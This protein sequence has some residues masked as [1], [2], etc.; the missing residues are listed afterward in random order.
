MARLVLTCVAQAEVRGEAARDLAAQAMAP[1]I[2]L[3]TDG[4]VLEP[5]EV[6]ASQEPSALLDELRA[7]LAAGKNAQ[8][9]MGAGSSATPAA[10]LS[11][12]HAGNT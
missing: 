11:H 5:V 4:G 7:Q 6:D 2:R 10:G 8:T 1:K 12:P 3:V 9:F